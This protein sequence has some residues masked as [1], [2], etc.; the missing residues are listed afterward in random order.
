MVVG[1]INMDVVNH[2]KRHP[3]L[4][5]TIEGLRTKYSPGGKGANQAIAASLAG[6]RVRMVGAVGEDTFASELL[7]QLGRFNVATD[8]IMRKKGTSGLAFITVDGYGENTIIL[9]KGANGRFLKIDLEKMRRV[10][11]SAGLLLLQ[12]EIPWETTFSA[13][14]IANENG[15]PVFFNPAPAMGQVNNLLK[16]IDLIVLNESEA[17]CMTGSSVETIEEATKAADQ[18][19]SGGVGSVVIT[20]GD[21]GSIYMDATHLSTYTPA[22]RVNPV[23]T[24]AAGD[25]F[26]GFLAARR[27]IGE[28]IEGALRYASAASAISVVHEG[29]Q[30]SIPRKDEVDTFLEGMP[31]IINS[32]M[33]F[34]S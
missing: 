25:T 20:L 22:F 6:A 27:W 19:I 33:A 32:S 14:Q 26:I 15:V 24:T 28:S 1:S 12:N 13:M 18:L 11:S 5:E 16:M 17:S 8:T 30:N 31:P 7:D 4:G 3:N 21:R 9:S 2:V 10:I 34:P 23:D 29:A